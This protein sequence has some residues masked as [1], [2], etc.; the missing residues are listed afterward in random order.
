MVWK[1]VLVSIVVTSSLGISFLFSELNQTIADLRATQTALQDT[2]ADLQKAQED[3]QR[4]IEANTSLTSDLEEAVVEVEDL[5][6]YVKGVQAD[7]EEASGLAS[8]R[9]KDLQ[10][11]RAENRTLD[12]ENKRISGSNSGLR[13]ELHKVRSENTELSSVVEQQK[14]LVSTRSE[15]IERLRTEV[16]RLQDTRGP[17]ILGYGDTSRSGFVCT[18]SMESVITCL[19]EATWLTNF[20]L[21]DIVVGATISYDPNCWSDADGIGTSHRVM[22]IKV[23]NDIYYFWPKGDNNL[24]DDGCWIPHTDVRGYI[25]EMHRNVLPANATLRGLVNAAKTA[26]YDASREYDA[27]VERYCNGNSQSCPRGQAY[28]LAV[29]AY[30]RLRAA[31]AHFFCWQD[32]AKDSEYPGH[33]PGEC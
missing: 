14:R 6:T 24:E 13:R 1:L 4:H 33:I 2:H 12:E 19:D 9:L 27:V 30:D 11:A 10:T 25:I 5:R 16:E 7:L 32:V 8:E 28:Q 23:E 26:Y 15:E 29:D 18:G 17:L 20:Y 22:N 3:R 21:A 31:S